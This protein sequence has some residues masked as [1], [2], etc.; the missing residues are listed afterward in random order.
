MDSCGEPESPRPK[1]ISEP[2]RNHESHEIEDRSE[3]RAAEGQLATPPISEVEW[4]IAICGP[5][6][7]SDDLNPQTSQRA[8]VRQAGGSWCARLHSESYSTDPQLHS[9][10]WTAG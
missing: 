2:L 10:H 1:P 7:A 5:T 9:G 4:A 6:D 8:V 3:S